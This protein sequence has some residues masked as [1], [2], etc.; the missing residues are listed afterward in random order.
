MNTLNTD[1]NRHK[2]YNTNVA[3]VFSLKRSITYN[4]HVAVPGAGGRAVEQADRAHEEFARIVE[5]LKQIEKY[6]AEI[7]ETVNRTAVSDEDAILKVEDAERKMNN[8]KFKKDSNNEI[9]EG[10]VSTTYT[11]YCPALLVLSLSMSH[12][13]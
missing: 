9:D 6:A 4:G 13:T 2:Y 7:E 8:L 5:E 11:F 3:R 10:Q 1:C 12:P